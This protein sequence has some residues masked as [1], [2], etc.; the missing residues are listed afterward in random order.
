MKRYT[1]LILL[2]AVVLLAVA[3]LWIVERP[4]PAADGSQA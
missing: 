3:P 1:N 2:T 4:A